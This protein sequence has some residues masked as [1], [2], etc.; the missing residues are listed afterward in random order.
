VI[1]SVSPDGNMYLPWTL[2]TLERALVSQFTTAYVVVGVLLLLLSL[3]RE[4]RQTP[5]RAAHGGTG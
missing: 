2:A 1:H 4:S 3:T 5:P